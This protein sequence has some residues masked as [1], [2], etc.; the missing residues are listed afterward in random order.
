MY[1]LTVVRTTYTVYVSVGHVEISAFSNK[2][3][4]A[5]LVGVVCKL[6]VRRRSGPYI[7]YNVCERGK[8]THARI[9]I[10]TLYGRVVWYGVKS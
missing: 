8:R 9:F 4:V 7:V 10:Q 1:L 2:L 3:R 6:D 5:K